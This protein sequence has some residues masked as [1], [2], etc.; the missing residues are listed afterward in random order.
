MCVRVFFGGGGVRSHHLNS[1]YLK[2][3]NKNSI[4]DTLK[5]ILSKESIRESADTPVY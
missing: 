4:T 2:V 1:K 3:G 5:K